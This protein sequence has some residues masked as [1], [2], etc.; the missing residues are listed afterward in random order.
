[1][2][3]KL[4][5]SFFESL[6]KRKKIRTC[7]EKDCLEPGYFQA[8]K[9]PDGKGWYY[10]CSNHIKTYNKRWNFFAGKNQKQIYDYQKN[11]FYQGRPTSPFTYG[12]SSKIKFEFEFFFDKENLQFNKRKHRKNCEPKINNSKL[13]KALN[14]F[15]LNNDFDEIK[16]KKRYKI[17][18]K[19]YHPDLNKNFLKKDNKIKE[20]NK[21]YN[22][23]LESLKKKT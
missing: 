3:K 5:K 13:E 1:M 15:S 7:D 12:K 4:N 20:I 21:S 19:K 22:I 6:E 16:L 14:T 17:L 2:K 9:S 11:D 10:F 23:L 18:V 8:P